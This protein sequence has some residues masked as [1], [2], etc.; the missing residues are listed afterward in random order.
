MGN[1]AANLNQLRI[2]HA[3]LVLSLFLCAFTTERLVGRTS[4]GYSAILLV[5]ILIV[6]GFDVRLGFYFRRTRLLPAIEKLRRDPNDSDALKQWRSAKL[7]SLVL[8]LT[9]GLYGLAIRFFGA[10]RQVSW[11]FYL[12]ALILMLAWRPQLDLRGEASNTEI[13]Q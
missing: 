3:I 12:V 6:A 2:Y 4:T 1:A 7:V 13:V 9:I 10:I 11:P 5:G 8:A